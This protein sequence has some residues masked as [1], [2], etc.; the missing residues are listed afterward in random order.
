M[1]STTRVVIKG[2][3]RLVELAERPSVLKKLKQLTNGGYGRRSS[4]LFYTLQNAEYTA[5]LARSKTHAPSVEDRL[6]KKHGSVFLAWA[7]GEVVAWLWVEKPSRKKST[8]GVFV[9]H[10]YRKRNLGT[11]LVARAMKY[12]N[13][14]GIKLYC[15]PWN[16]AGRQLFYKFEKLTFL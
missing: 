9:H 7:K 15:E 1:K 8:I 13:N 16:K 5:L 11:R 14:E 10:T 12:A 2:P 3:Y 4:R 6:L